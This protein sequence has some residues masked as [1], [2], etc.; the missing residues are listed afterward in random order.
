MFSL[1]DSRR[2]V[3]LICKIYETLTV[4]LNY[5]VVLTESKFLK[6]KSGQSC[7]KIRL[8][9]ELNITKLIKFNFLHL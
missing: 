7:T 9:C 8:K 6:L 4:T 1:T 3:R 2:V 5:S